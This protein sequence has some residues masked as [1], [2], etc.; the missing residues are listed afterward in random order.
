MVKN[1]INQEMKRI[2]AII[3]VLA[4]L[5]PLGSFIYFIDKQ[6]IS[7]FLKQAQTEKHYLFLLI[8][9]LGVGTLIG[10]VLYADRKS[11]K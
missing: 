7:G 8:L 1:T 3:W 6:L 4:V 11:S 10:L 5:I 9:L 2:S